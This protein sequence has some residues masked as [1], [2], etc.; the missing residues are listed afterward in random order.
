MHDILC[1]EVEYLKCDWQQSAPKTNGL[2]KN[3]SAMMKNWGTCKQRFLVGL[4]VKSSSMKSGSHDDLLMAM[5]KG[6][7]LQQSFVV[8]IKIFSVWSH[9]ESSCLT[10]NRTASCTASGWS[11][12]QGVGDLHPVGWVHTPA[13]PLEALLGCVE[14]TVITDGAESGHF[15]R[16]R[17]LLLALGALWSS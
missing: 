10:G 5:L 7:K 13:G 17:S 1:V 3:L 8:T 4:T 9:N 14:T 12:D 15:H 16:I 6:I 11:I 2:S